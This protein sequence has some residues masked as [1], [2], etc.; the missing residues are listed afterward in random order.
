MD[1]RLKFIAFSCFVSSIKG[2]LAGPSN[3]N[4][5]ERTLAQDTQG[6]DE[7]TDLSPPQ[8][9]PRGIPIKIGVLEGKTLRAR[10]TVGREK[11]RERGLTSSLY[12][13]HRSPRAFFFPLPSLP[14]TQ[15]GL[16]TW[17]R[18]STHISQINFCALQFICFPSSLASSRTTLPFPFLLNLIF[19]EFRIRNVTR[20]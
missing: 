9:H 11:R 13:S 1:R 4:K 17:R 3:E 16:C 15:R 5:T 18:V 8:R 14:R 12:P 6:S 20:K 10:W 7:H 19:S 2:F